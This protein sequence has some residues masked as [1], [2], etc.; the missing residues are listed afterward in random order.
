MP[1]GNK[2]RR[3]FGTALPETYRTNSGKVFFA[4]MIMFYTE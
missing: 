1:S 4:K 3:A 2:N